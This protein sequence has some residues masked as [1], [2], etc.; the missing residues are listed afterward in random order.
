M[1][2]RSLDWYRRPETIL[3]D[4]L[5]DAARGPTANRAMRRALVVAVD[6]E[7]GKLQNPDGSGQVRSSWP[8]QREIVFPAVVGPENPR[9]SIKARI[10]TDGEDRL[11]Q[12]GDLRVFWPLFPPDQIGVPVAPGEHVFVMF[13]GDGMENGLWMSRV[14]GHEGASAYVGNQSYVATSAPGSAMDHFEPNTADYSKT[15][16]HAGLAPGGTAMDHFEDE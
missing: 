3:A 15:E 12:D 16:R 9:G 5:R 8:G 7:G 11:R 6:Y 10:L 4:L 14:A 2:R 1:S 13:E